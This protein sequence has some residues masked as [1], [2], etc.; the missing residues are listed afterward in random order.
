VAQF[1]NPTGIRY[2]CQARFLAP[3]IRALLQYPI[4]GGGP[5][6]SDKW[7]RH[8]AAA[9]GTQT[10]SDTDILLTS[11]NSTRRNVIRRNRQ[12]W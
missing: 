9:D 10:R 8:R 7:Q 12:A 4:F 5:G 6:S 1:W 3:D 2:R 11:G